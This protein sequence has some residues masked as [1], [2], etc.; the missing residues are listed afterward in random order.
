MRHDR[1]VARTVLVVDDHPAFRATARMLL[2]AAGWDVTGEAEDVAGA[3]EAIGRLHPQV[4]LLDVQLPDGDGFDVLAA[5]AGAG[6]GPSPDVVLVSSRDRCDYGDRIEAS[7]ARGF[8]AKAEL[9]GEAL[10]EVLA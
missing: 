4:V 2:E 10:D 1:P 7:G 5:L 3:L 9:T 6:P 8:I